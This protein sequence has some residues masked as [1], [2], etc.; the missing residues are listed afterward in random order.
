MATGIGL[1]YK[2]VRRSCQHKRNPEHFERCKAALEAA[3]EAEGKGL[4]NRFTLMSRAFPRNP[5]YPMPGSPKVVN[6][7][8]PQ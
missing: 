1:V 2:R 7:A 6:S 4:I 8:F 5:V 3:Q